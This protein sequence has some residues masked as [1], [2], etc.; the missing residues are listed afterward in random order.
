[1]LLPPPIPSEQFNRRIKVLDLAWQQRI[2]AEQAHERYKQ[3]ARALR[4]AEVDKMI[5]KMLEFRSAGFSLPQRKQIEELFD[6]RSRAISK[7][8]EM[9]RALFKSIEEV[10]R[11]DQLRAF[12]HLRRTRERQWYENEI[13]SGI[14]QSRF[15]NLTDIVV[16]LDLPE[17]E[18][19]AV[20]APLA[21]YE[22]SFN[23]AI[24]NLH[25]ATIEMMLDMIE[26]LADAGLGEFEPGEE[27]NQAEM[28]R[29]MGVV[30]RVMQ[31][32]SKDALGA[33]ASA[34]SI[35]RRSQQQIAAAL[36][37]E[38]AEAFTRR[39]L[40]DAYPRIYRQ[41]ASL[42][43]LFENVR[44]SEELTAEQKA[45]V[46]TFEKSWRDAY[47][48]VARRMTAIADQQRDRLPNIMDFMGGDNELREKMQELEEERDALNERTLASVAAV[49]GEDKAQTLRVG[50]RREG[51]SMSFSVAAGGVIATEEIA[52][53][54]ENAAES[55]PLEPGRGAHFAIPGAISEAAFDAYASRLGLEE[56]Q[57]IVAEE[58]LRQY[59]DEYD[60]L[61]SDRIRQLATPSFGVEDAKLSDVDTLQQGR[62]TAF[63]LVE[64]LDREFFATIESLLSEDQ[65]SRLDAI[66]HAR[67]CARR[68]VG[69]QASVGQDESFVDLNLLLAS[70][71]P[72]DE[73]W[74]AVEPVLRNAERELLP[75]LTEQ[76]ETAMERETARIRMGIISYQARQEG[77]NQAGWEVWS[78]TIQP[79]E[80][81]LRDLAERRSDLQRRAGED[82]LAELSSESGGRLAQRLNR[83]AYPEIFPDRDDAEPV[84][85]RAMQ[86]RDLSDEQAARIDEI[87][88]EHRRGYDEI[89][90]EMMR[91]VDERGSRPS[92]DPENMEDFQAW[93]EAEQA[94]RRLRQDRV[95][96][97]ETTRRSLRAALARD[98]AAR[99]R[100]LDV[101]PAT[102]QAALAPGDG[103]SD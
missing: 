99:V 48:G 83:I 2:A 60:A 13:S 94:L 59:R 82:M 55:R 92:F 61:A 73:D 28:M 100:G 9:D 32:A 17:S 65:V 103:G 21:E 5:E 3:R 37:P 19:D 68:D 89:C 50:P 85:V 87:Y 62:Q 67:A 20:E 43:P 14:F 91:L 63:D 88:S 8:V 42:E 31:K 12:G 25:D 57:R 1:V 81:R 78:E 22:R 90:R 15:P 80:E 69:R 16:S 35:T 29:I 70:A 23:I 75:L 7:I 96:W 97:N 34:R 86:L 45:Q 39:Y 51:R 26:A 54:F 76:W 33:A 56:N 27:P 71:D 11:E 66:R 95:E 102:E 4:E 98:Q 47:K 49:I 72:S 101:E 10:L 30:T 24:H 52:A 77:D 38:H 79:I 44:A 6:L 36:S 53:T 93:Q 18:L 84:I 40:Q 64:E 46:A 58:L 41:E 74:R